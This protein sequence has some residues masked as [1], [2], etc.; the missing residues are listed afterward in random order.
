M[1]KCMRQLIGN[2]NVNY[3]GSILKINK[4][5]IKVIKQLYTNTSR[6]CQGL[7]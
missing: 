2:K 6:M 7:K 4:P 5:I 3:T 1:R